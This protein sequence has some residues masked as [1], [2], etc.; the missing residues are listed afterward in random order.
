MLNIDNKL[1]IPKESF[2]D[3]IR[4]DKVLKVSYIKNES[5]VSVNLIYYGETASIK[6]MTNIKQQN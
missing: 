4:E 2:L 1:V 3:V 6:A 5:V